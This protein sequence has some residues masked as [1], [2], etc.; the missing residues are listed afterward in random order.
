MHLGMAGGGGVTY[1]FRVNMTLT[2]D[3]DFRI[4]VSGTYLILFEMHLGM[5]ERCVSFIGH[6]DFKLNLLNN[7]V[8]GISHII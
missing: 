3:I 7:F 4:I 2:S 8:W 6:I 1:H 5:V